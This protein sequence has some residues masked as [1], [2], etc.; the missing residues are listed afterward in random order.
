MGVPDKWN[1]VDVFGLDNDALAWV[2][3]PVL[4]VIL[5]FPCSKQV[6]ENNI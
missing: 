5:L 2:P 6:I 3:R 4:S 1:V